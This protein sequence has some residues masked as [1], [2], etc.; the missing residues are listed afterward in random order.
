MFFSQFVEATES[1]LT[2]DE[3][4]TIFRAVL[5]CIYTDHCQLDAGCVVETLVAAKKYQGRMHLTRL[6][7][8]FSLSL[9]VQNAE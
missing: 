8:G 5:H 7:V 2:I 9:S 1:Q 3:P 4:P 6:I